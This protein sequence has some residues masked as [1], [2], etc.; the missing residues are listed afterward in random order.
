MADQ[1]G[2]Q[3]SVCFLSGGLTIRGELRLPRN[4]S[5]PCPIVLLGHG[6]GALKEWTL[7]EVAEAFAKDGIAGLWFDYRNYGD[8]DGEPRDEVSHYGRLEDWHSAIRYAET[9]P[10]IDGKSIGI[11]G[12]SLGGRDVLAMASIDPRVKAVVAQTPVIKWTPSLAT[13][14]SEYG[15]DVERYHR[16]LSDDR[17]KRALGAE[18]RYLPYV[19]ESGN[20]AKAEYLGAMG[21]A[22]LRNYKARISLQSFQSS[23]LTDV[24]PLVKLISPRPLLFILAEQDFLP[25]QREAYD[26]A[27]DPKF[28]V[29]I[30]GNHFSP[31][32][33]SK[34]EAID[35]A[36]EWFIEYLIDK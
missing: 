34:K 14:M 35:A 17:K 28:L 29:T 18:P 26:A 6:L 31:Y 11:W 32:G 9:L 15:D 23:V 1:S 20:D 12:T 19:K 33:N 30:E 22:E 8:S 3:R 24:A 4:T 36:K 7:P 2:E 27:E 16:E 13:R 10:E 21:A 25:G 5:K